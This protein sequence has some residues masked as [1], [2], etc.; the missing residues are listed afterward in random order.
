[1]AKSECL[2]KRV[3]R[4]LARGFGEAV[5]AQRLGVSTA[6]VR[7]AIGQI[8]SSGECCSCHS[9]GDGTILANCSRPPCQNSGAETNG[10][11]M[12]ISIGGAAIELPDKHN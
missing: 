1:M 7:A 9:N 11:G 3:Q 2:K 5:I 6:E 10:S 8:N 4:Y 12:S